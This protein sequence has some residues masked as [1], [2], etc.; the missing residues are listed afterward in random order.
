LANVTSAQ[1][2][3]QTWQSKITRLEGA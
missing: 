1:H 3:T 2:Y